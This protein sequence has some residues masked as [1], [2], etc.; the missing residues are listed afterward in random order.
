VTK[1][2]ELSHD[3]AKQNIMK[4]NIEGLKITNA[5]ECVANEIMQHL[6]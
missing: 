5:D 3:E 6:K 1:I 2:I 4:K